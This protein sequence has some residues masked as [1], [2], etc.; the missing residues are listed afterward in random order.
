MTYE[1]PLPNPESAV[2]GP[3]EAEHAG[4]AAVRRQ[5]QGM[6]H[7]EAARAFHLLAS[8]ADSPA[9]KDIGEPSADPDGGCRVAELAEWERIVDQLAVHAGTYDVES[10]PYVQGERAA[11]G[12]S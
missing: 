11:S 10:D 2:E 5:A 1:Q 8:R 6:T 4:R 7:H 9:P 3:T 12:E